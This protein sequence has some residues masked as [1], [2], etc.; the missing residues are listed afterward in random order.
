MLQ[1]HGLKYSYDG[2][3]EI[4]YPDWEVEKG[5][6]ALILGNSGCGKTTLLHL[7]GG[8]M[9][10]S[11]GHLE[12]EGEDLAKKSSAKLDKF[13]GE[14][15]GIVF[16]KPH[17]VKS[18]TVREN[19]LLAQYLGKKEQGSKRVNEVIE[20]LGI[21]ELANRKVHQISQGQAQRVSIARAVVNSPKLLL[22]DEPTASLDDENCMKVID[23]LRSQAEETGATL[24]VATHDHRV[25]SEFQN[26]LS[27]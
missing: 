8:L 3:A 20:H 21:S 1:I 13:R 19:L 24:I 15:I 22:A 5:N 23:L 11:A 27:L 25:K 14:N 7:I 9:Q 10:P 17:L 2:Q 6:H 4:S 12:I 18:L 26:Q 16:Q